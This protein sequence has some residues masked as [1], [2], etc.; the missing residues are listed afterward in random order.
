MFPNLWVGTAANHSKQNLGASQIIYVYLE[1]KQQKFCS[2]TFNPPPKP[3]H[4]Y[5]CLATGIPHLEVVSRSHK[6]TD[7]GQSSGAF[8]RTTLRD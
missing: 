6:Q 4:P 8:G 5:L 3:P 7:F 2:K 1:K